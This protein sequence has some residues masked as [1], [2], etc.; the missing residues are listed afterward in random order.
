MYKIAACDQASSTLLITLLDDMSTSNLQNITSCIV[1]HHVLL[2]AAPKAANH[3]HI[4]EKRNITVLG[5][6]ELK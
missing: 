3:P 1:P 5:T 6:L 4:K 2:Y